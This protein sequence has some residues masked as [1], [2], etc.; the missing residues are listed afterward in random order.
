MPRF[1]EKV[2]CL[3]TQSE[4]R[5]TLDGHLA[6]AFVQ[7]A[8]GD[9]RTTLDAG[10][11]TIG[12]HIELIGKPGAPDDQEVGVA[13]PDHPSP[14]PQPIVSL[15]I[16]GKG[17]RGQLV[18]LGDDGRKVFVF[19]G[20]S[21]ELSIG[22]S[23][24]NG[25]VH[26]FNALGQESVRLH[27]GG[28]TIGGEGVLFPRL[29]VLD[30]GG[31]EA[32]VVEGASAEL[33]VGRP[34]K[35][36]DV[37]VFNQAGQVTVHLDGRAGD[38]ELLGADCAEEFEID[39]AQPL[40]PGMVMVITEGSQ[41]RPCG[42]AYDRKVAGVLSGA[43]DYRP[44]IVL[45]K[46]VSSHGRIPIALVGRAYCKVDAR[47]APIE[48]GDLLTTSDTLGHAMKA[49]DPLR[50]FGAVIGKALRPLQEGTGLLPVLI[51]LQ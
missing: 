23:G 44:G 6:S 14:P 40:E 2:E 15:T 8:A 17:T 27:P 49:S 13:D 21:A 32:F 12:P 5:I 47:N 20:G 31:K 33:S 29:V 9:I 7:N 45:G 1:T 48:I 26:V 43:G 11:I 19:D 34:G 18:M 16:G 41:L 3:D 30:S 37:R 36:G 24:S 39:S 10:S 38:I 51:A 22:R 42:E 28:V 25:Q 35:A 46:R 50:A 4:V